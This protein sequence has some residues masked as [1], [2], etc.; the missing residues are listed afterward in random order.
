[1]RSLSS[2][3]S[4]NRGHSSFAIVRKKF[5]GVFKSESASE[6]ISDGQVAGGSLFL[7]VDLTRQMPLHVTCSANII[8]NSIKGAI[9]L[10]GL[11]NASFSGTRI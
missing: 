4:R 6:E 5:N 3:L 7:D 9:K 11:G 1:M 2:H 8:E 10:G